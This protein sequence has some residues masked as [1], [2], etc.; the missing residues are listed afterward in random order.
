MR[1]TVSFR[2]PCAHCSQSSLVTACS[3]YTFFLREVQKRNL[4]RR[5]TGRFSQTAELACRRERRA[6]NHTALQSLEE[7]GMGGESECD[8]IKPI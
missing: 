8:S 7:E 3:P 1:Y 6:R 4:F 5:Y 2:I